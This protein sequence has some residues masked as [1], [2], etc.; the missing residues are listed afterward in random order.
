M[1]IQDILYKQITETCEKEI[2][3][4]MH[5]ALEQKNLEDRR[6]WEAWAYGAYIAWRSI[7]CKVFEADI[8]DDDA[9]LCGLTERSA[10]SEV[11]P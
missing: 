2:K 1:N 11:R 5:V 3:N 7:C 4:L 6:R 10:E 8:T 9:R